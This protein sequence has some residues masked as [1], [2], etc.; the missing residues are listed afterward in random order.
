MLFKFYWTKS[1]TPS[2]VSESEPK[3]KYGYNP[4][5]CLLMDS[6]GLDKNST[7]EWI[8]EA[9]RN[10][11]NIKEEK[12]ESYYWGRE[13]WAAD[14]SKSFVIVYSLNDESVKQ[15]I[16]LESF[17]IILLKWKEFLLKENLSEQKFT[18]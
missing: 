1:S 10:I 17:K 5:D 12:I 18:I 11:K 9:L 6:G 13:S 14:I 3:E 7:L 4:L 8:R 16:E 15:E 2:P